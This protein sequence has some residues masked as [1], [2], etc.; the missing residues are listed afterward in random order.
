MNWPRWTPPKPEA[1]V[2]NPM[3]GL[4]TALRLSQHSPS[5]MDQRG[6]R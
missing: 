3:R 4:F 1:T 6:G 5:Q 2:V